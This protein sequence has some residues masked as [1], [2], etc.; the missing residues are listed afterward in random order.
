MTRPLARAAALAVLLCTLA[1]T[2][3][4]QS[5]LSPA[6]QRALDGATAAQMEEAFSAELEARTADAANVICFRRPKS[7]QLRCRMLN[8]DQHPRGQQARAPSIRRA[9]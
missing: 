5:T 2:A 4:A 3:A 7:H 1:H 6:W 8:E 9:K